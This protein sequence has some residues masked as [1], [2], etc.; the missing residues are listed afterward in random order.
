MLLPVLKGVLLKN[1]DKMLDVIKY[2]NRSEYPRHFNS[3]N[4]QETLN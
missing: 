4:H 3:R 1:Q 2:W